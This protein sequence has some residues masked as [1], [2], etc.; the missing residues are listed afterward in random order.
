ME[1]TP[2]DVP[3]E[4]TGELPL[5]ERVD[6]LSQIIS[7]RS[8]EG[9]SIVD[10]DDR[11]VTAVLMRQGQHVNHVLHAII[12]IFTCGLWVIVWAVIGMTHRREERIRVTIDP[13]GRL[14]EER[15]TPA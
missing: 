8:L 1:E 12:S 13:S 6:R 4:V 11:K 14:I 5:K 10:R 15:F 9:Y 7:N 3:A 2:G